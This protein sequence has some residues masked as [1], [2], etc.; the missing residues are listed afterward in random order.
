MTT[1]QCSS[2]FRNEV[3]ALVYVGVH[4]CISIAEAGISHVKG[5]SRHSSELLVAEIIHDSSAAV[6]SSAQLD[7]DML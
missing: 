1:W 7:T 4:F 6:L 2:Q 3:R 5:F